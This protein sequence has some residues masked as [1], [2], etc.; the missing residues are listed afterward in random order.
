MNFTKSLGRFIA[1][2]ISVIL[3]PMFMPVYGIL[4]LFFISGTFLSYLPGPVKRIVFIIIAVNTIILPLSVVPF[5]VSQKI[6]KSIHMDT[7]RERIIPLAMNSIFYY[8]GFYLLN[9]LQVPDLIKMYVL[10]S[11]SVVVVTL[12]VS[13]KW[14]ISIHMVGIGGLTGAIISISWHLGVD[15]KVVWMGLILCSGLIGFARLELNKHTPAQVYSGFVTGFI[16]AGGVL[17]VG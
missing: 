6:I 11:F 1:K 9:R 12:L 17:M 14:K 13:L 2:I 4:I 7:S 15:M 8:L 3:H 5:Y 10:A 16:V